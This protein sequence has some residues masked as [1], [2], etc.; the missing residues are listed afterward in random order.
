V[1]VLALAVRVWAYATHT[2]IAFP[3][4]TFQYLEPAHWLAFGSGVIAWEFVDGIRS[5]LLPGV[6]AGIMRG[7]AWIDPDPAISIAVL[8]LPCILASL[9]IPY[10]G[11][12][13]AERYGG[14]G[15][16]LAA[17]LLCALSPQAVYYA[18]VAM[19][20]GLATDAALLAIAFA[21]RPLVAGA[22]F[23]LACSLRYQYAPILAAVALWQHVRDVRSFRLVVLSGIAT[24]VLALGVLDTLTWGVPFQSVWLNY[25]RNGPQG[26][27][28]A[29]GEEGW[30]YYLH[31]FLVAWGALTPLVLVLLAVG[32]RP[33]PVLAVAAVATIGLHMLPAHKEMRFILLASVAMPIPMGLGIDALLQR[34]APRRSGSLAGMALALGLALLTV[35]G[36][37]SRATGPDEWHRD[38]SMLRAT[39]SA[40]SIVGVWGLA[41]RTIGVYRTG[42]YAYWHRDVP[43]YFEAWDRARTIPGSTIELHLDSVLNGRSVPQY[44]GAALA[45]H[46]DAFNA[47]VGSPDDGLPTYPASGRIS[48]CVAT[49]SGCRMTTAAS[50]A[51]FPRGDHDPPGRLLNQ[52][53]RCDGNRRDR[54]QYPGILPPHRQRR[55]ARPETLVPGRVVR[56]P[57]ENE[58]VE[59]IHRETDLTE[60]NR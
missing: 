60:I 9:S 33:A 23:G 17:G 51:T 58:L 34:L 13:I 5:W 46:T 44:P 32:A 28:Q 21:R 40:R 39:A 56:M 35:W 38:E 12:R 7:V 55:E 27:S 19:T 10:A 4:E 2:Y 1:L 59:K 47:I 11:F 54:R 8:R 18:P 24:V 52:M 45:A 22:L 25:L 6:I 48:L 53:M 49:R 16:A 37:L 36:T 43:I 30:S 50:A 14:S 41:I 26:F 31:Y 42:G 57:P 29:I 15:G 3:D 20:D